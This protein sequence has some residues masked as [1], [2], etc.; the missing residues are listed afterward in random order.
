[1]NG[2]ANAATIVLSIIGTGVTASA[3]LA[4]VIVMGRW[5]LTSPPFG[6]PPWV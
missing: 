6:A 2:M 1:M 4:T 3:L 5:T